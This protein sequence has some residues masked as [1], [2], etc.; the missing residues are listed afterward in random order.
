MEGA[1]DMTQRE[2]EDTINRLNSSL[3]QLTQMFQLQM[4]QLQIQSQQLQDLTE[5][6]K[7]KDEEI[8][9]LKEQL[10]KNS[11][12]SS[13]PP[14]SDG[15]KKPAPKSSRRKSGKHPGGQEGHPGSNL[16]APEVPKTYEYHMPSCCHGCPN[17]E[18]CR[19]NGCVC[20][21][22]Q[23]VDAKVEV[24]VTEHQQIKIRKCPLNP[25]VRNVKGEFPEEITAP[26]Q[27]G[28]GLQALVVALN[29]Y[30]AVSVQRT[31]DILAGVFSLPLSVGSIQAMLR[32]CAKQ[33]SEILPWIRE[34][35]SNSPLMHC[36][37]TGGRINGKL[38]WIHFNGNE[39]FS[40]LTLNPY[41]GHK[42]MTAIGILPHYSG[43]IVHDCWTA[44]WKYPQLNH[45]ICNA[46]ILR[47]LNG[48][49]ENYP[50]Q[51]W[52][53]D[54]RKLLLE[55]KAVA[56]KAHQKEKPALSYYYRHKF[57]RKYDEIINAGLLAN[58][59]PEEPE[60]KRGRKKKGKIRALIERLQSNKAA[61]C[62]FVN[63]LLMP[64]DNNLAE[65]G[66][67][68]TKAKFKIAGCFRTSEGC[69]DYLDIMSY[70][71]SAKKHGKSAYEA[72]CM[73]VIGTP[74]LI[75]D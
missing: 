32:Q 36:D 72:I 45:A 6:L 31:H 54:F 67:R 18:E 64:F 5:L 23:V 21:R 38:N 10:N 1:S 33:L 66:L 65:R 58:P 27:Y 13:K 11:N 51:K 48:V 60:G 2:Y 55:M 70:V 47:E 29:T 62:L 20:A 28:K 39:Q 34:Q 53:N 44:Y 19:K 75:F 71:D 49:T 63:D 43:T 15:Y 40:L 41:R 42:G 8:A 37:E 35:L 59:L 52:A 9:R 24:S 3:E 68:M 16:F 69:Q 61:V 25:A 26:V 57:S 17:T 46:H 73:A 56:D 74:E 14:S 22:R 50:E 7:A 4:Q 12:N 30:G